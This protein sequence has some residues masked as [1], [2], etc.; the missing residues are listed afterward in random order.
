MMLS[1]RQGWRTRGVLLEPDADLGAAR[2]LVGVARLKRL[3]PVDCHMAADPVG[4]G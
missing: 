3:S 1:S 4:R 2:A